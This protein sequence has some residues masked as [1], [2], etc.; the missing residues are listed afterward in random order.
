MADETSDA[1]M[2]RRDRQA[3]RVFL[4]VVD[5]SEEMHVA[6]RFA[7]RR[8]AATGGRVALFSALEPSDFGHWQAV[9]DLI[10]QEQREEAE[11]AIKKYA[12]Q[13]HEMCGKMPVVYIRKGTAG[14]QLLQLLGEE[15]SISILVLAAGT[16][17]KG[18]GPLISAL[19][20]KLYSRVQVPITIVPGTLSDEDVDALT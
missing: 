16:G 17:S 15:P 7:S 9:D 14:D 2:R 20:G 19:T 12:D 6:L 5:E 1:A 8:A 13:V 4:V 11:T 18:P 10:E 3:E